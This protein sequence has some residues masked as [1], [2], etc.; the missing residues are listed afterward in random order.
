[1][2]DLNECKKLFIVVKYVS[3][4][5]ICYS[6]VPDKKFLYSLTEITSSLSDVGVIYSLELNGILLE[7]IHITLINYITT[8]LVFDKALQDND[9]DSL[10]PIASRKFSERIIREIDNSSSNYFVVQGTIHNITLMPP[11]YETNCREGEDDLEFCMTI[12]SV[13]GIKEAVNRYPFSEMLTLENKD[14]DVKILSTLD[15]K[16]KTLYDQ[17]REVDNQCRLECNFRICKAT[18]TLTD[19]ADYATPDVNDTLIL[20]AGVPKSNGLTVKTLAAM[21]LI[22]YLNHLCVS[23]SIWLGISVLS[24]FPM[25]RLR[26]SNKET[27]KKWR[28]IID[29]S[30][31]R[32]MLKKNKKLFP[33]ETK[34]ERRAKMEN[35]ISMEFKNKL[36]QMKNSNSNVRILPR[37]YCPCE[38]CRSHF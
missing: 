3:G 12:C 2:R 29:L 6:F 5:D 34:R 9:M 37:I 15:L 35:I 22:E 19:A 33:R 13:Q 16:N 30:K 10:T 1:M 11:P 14:P 26:G 38:Y 23:G 4:E 8:A 18:Y 31:K 36:F 24:F 7:A 32:K 28:D 27:I 25:K 20:V 17:V 21:N